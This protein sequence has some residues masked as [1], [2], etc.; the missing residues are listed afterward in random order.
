MFIDGLGQ[1]AESLAGWLD[2]QPFVF[3]FAE[4]LG[5]VGL[6]QSAQHQIGIRQSQLFA[7]S[8]AGWSRVG[9]YAFRSN[10]KHAIVKC[11]FGPTSSRNCIDLKMGSA[12]LYPLHFEIIPGGE[13]FLLYSWDISGGSSHIQADQIWVSNG[14]LLMGH[15]DIF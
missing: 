11:Q 14:V 9:T 10:H 4:Y 12:E 13:Q 7:Y 2:V 15:F 3:V 1:F 5:E 8:V 6:V